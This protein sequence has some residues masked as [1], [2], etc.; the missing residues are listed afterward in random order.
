MLRLTIKSQF[1]NN[2]EPHEANLYDTIKMIALGNTPILSQSLYFPRNTLFYS[3]M[4]KAIQS[5]YIKLGRFMYVSQYSPLTRLLL[6][7][8]VTH[9]QSNNILPCFRE[10]SLLHTSS[11][12]PVDEGSLSLLHIKLHIK[13]MTQ[14]TPLGPG[15]RDG[16][17]V[18]EHAH[19]TGGT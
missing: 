5:V 17:Y 6:C 18:V 9:L 8:L 11:H 14:P 4:V 1:Y 15:F 10:L 7:H 16:C 19:G 13:L 2:D 3:K 12:V